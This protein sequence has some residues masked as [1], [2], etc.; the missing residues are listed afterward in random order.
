[1]LC[2]T[3]REQAV[4]ETV[5]RPNA[6]VKF[7][8]FAIRLTPS[9]EVSL[10]FGGMAQTIPNDLIDVSQRNGRV[11]LN[12]LLCCGAIP[13]CYNYRIDRNAC[14][15]HPHHTIGALH[16]RDG[17]CD[18]FQ[19]C[20]QASAFSI[21]GQGSTSRTMALVHSNGENYSCKI[22]IQTLIFA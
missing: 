17:F 14:S 5:R 8:C 4:T 1:M 13:K 22:L 19:H 20:P 6:F 2:L 15:T 12:D 16:E 11:L 10:N 21:T 18:Y 7:S 3:P 9:T